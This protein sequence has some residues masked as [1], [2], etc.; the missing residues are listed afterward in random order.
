MKVNNKRKEQIP[1]SIDQ[2]KPTQ[3]INLVV[4]LGTSMSRT[5]KGFVQ[6][7]ILPA[8][9]HDNVV[10]LALDTSKEVGNIVKGCQKI[11]PFILG[12]QSLNGDGCGMKRSLANKAFD[13]SQEELKQIIGPPKAIRAAIVMAGPGRGCTSG[14]VNKTCK[15]IRELNI[16]VVS[17]LFKSSVEAFEMGPAQNTEFKQSLESLLRDNFKIMLVDQGWLYD[18]KG[19]RQEATRIMEEKVTATLA[20]VI[21]CWIGGSLLDRCDLIHQ[22]LKHA[23]YLTSVRCEFNR[24]LTEQEEI[25]KEVELSFTKA[26]SQKLFH[27]HGA[28]NFVGTFPHQ[29]LPTLYDSA[30]AGCLKKYCG[31]PV[32]EDYDKS[33]RGYEVNPPF[34]YKIK[35][36]TRQLE[37]TTDEDSKQGYTTFLFSTMLWEYVQEEDL[38]DFTGEQEEVTHLAQTPQSGPEEK[39]V[40]GVR[41]SRSYEDF[42]Q[43]S[44]LALKNNSEAIRCFTSGDPRALAGVL[45]FDSGEGHKMPAFRFRIRGPELGNKLTSWP[46]QRSKMPLEDLILIKDYLPGKQFSPGWCQI[47]FDTIQ[48]ALQQRGLLLP[49][50]LCNTILNPKKEINWMEAT[51]GTLR[52]NKDWQIAFGE[53]KEQAWLCLVRSGLEQI[54]PQD[55]T[56]QNKIEAMLEPVEARTLMQRAK[57]GTK[58]FFRRKVN[59]ISGGKLGKPKVRAVSNAQPPQTQTVV[60][61]PE[62]KPLSVPKV[63]EAGFPLNLPKITEVNFISSAISSNGQDKTPTRIQ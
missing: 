43:L 59:T 46:N 57:Q 23:G 12:K 44:S 36:E 48:A 17:V 40:A 50:Y 27:L 39:R 1:E 54:L 62:T 38:E 25:Q 16:P 30:F 9:F 8:K 11:Q 42:E 63:E 49:R 60:M 56:Y 29:K 37:N 26:T 53:N 21:P 20:D 58:E 15:M 34:P 51:P 7:P 3:D 19:D 2:I 41:I 35:A 13:E 4:S 14:L 45:I 22:V 32:G 55:E 18:Q 61:A 6:S 52:T 24:E 31:K 10:A 28:I 5:L 47:F 33:Q